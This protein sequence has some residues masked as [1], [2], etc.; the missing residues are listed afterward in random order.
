MKKYMSRILALCLAGAMMLS[1][2]ACGGGDVSDATLANPNAGEGKVFTEP[3]ELDITVSSHVSWPY[4][5]NWVMF[6]YIGEATGANLNLT[7]LPNADMDTKLSL[8]MASPET[9]PDLLHTWQKKTVDDYALSGAYLSYDDYKDLMPNMNAFIESIPEAERADLLAMRTSGDGKM[10]SAPAY[11][12]QTVN[13]LRT[14]IYRKD[15]FEKH[16]LAVPTTTEELYQVAKKLKELY[17]D[18]YPIC[19]RTGIGKF[20]EWGPSWQRYFTHNAYYDF[21]TGEWKL[22]ALEPVMKEMVEYFLMLKNEGLVPPDYITMETKGWEELMSTDRGFITLDYIVRIDFFNTPNRQQNPDYTLAM[23]P[24]PKPT[25]AQASHG[26]YKGNQDY[27]G[28][29][30]CNTGRKQ[31]AE[32]AFKFVNWFYT[33]EAVDLI[34]WG[35]E[36]E[37]YNVVDGKKKFIL[38]ADEQPKAVYGIATYGTYQV[39]HTEANEALY[40]DEQV[41]ACHE[42]LQYLMPRSN[43]TTWIPLSQEQQNEMLTLKNDLYNYI[44]EGLSK[45]LLGQTPMSEWDTYQQTLRD[46]GAERL[47]EIYSEAYDKVASTK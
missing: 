39:I 4:N 34:S 28:Y 25:T 23:M 32:N 41:D 37:T 24:P 5:E 7:A 40:S 17:P 10:Y 31:D 20:E 47:L 29:T 36:G 33:D 13:N 12:T 1:L 42:V 11:G 16:G 26:L 15:I 3:T 38:N 44:S 46:M 27:Y 9:L 14:W 21:D 30:V 45:F 35:K 18:S 43:P 2:A 8:M 22:G 6:K 19:F